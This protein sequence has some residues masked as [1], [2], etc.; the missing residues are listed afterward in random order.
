MMKF[1]FLGT[2]A[3][4][5]LA[6]AGGFSTA[7]AQ[8]SDADEIRIEDTIT[9]TA[10]KTDERLEDVPAGV[11]VL[12]EESSELLVLDGI[13]DVLRQVPNAI[14]VNAGP[15]YLSDISIRGQGGGRQGFSESSTGIYRN[16]IYIA[17][18][19]F[20]GRSFNRLDFFD[21]KTI[22]T[23][24]GPQGA[25]Y[26]RNAVG[27]AVNVINNKP[28]DAPYAQ[29]K[30]G[31]EDPERYSISGIVNTPL[32]DNVAARFGAFYIDQ[33]DGFVTDQN[34][35][36]AVDKQE[37]FG[38]R[39][40]LRAD[41]SDR[42]T[43]T[44]TIEHYD[45]TAPGFSALGQRITPNTVAL[46]PVLGGPQSGDLDPGPYEST[47]SRVGVVEIQE[48]SIFGELESD[49]DIGDFTVIVAYKQRDGDRFNEDLDSFLGFQGVDILGITTDLTV[50]QTE[51]FERLGVEM[52]LASKL[53]SSLRWL[54]GADFQTFD[55]DV[56]TINGGT[57]GLGG[58]AALATRTETFTE[59]LTSFSAFG[60][61]GFD[62]SE[63]LDLTLEARLQNDSKDFIFMREQSGATVID[64]G[65]LDDSWTRFLPAATL[66]YDVNE[67]QIIFLRAASG[68]RPGGFNTGVD[69]TSIDL[70]PYDPETAYSLE[71]GWKGRFS[72]S[73]RFGF[74]AF[75]VMTD[76]VQ[77]VSTLSTMDTTTALQN[78]GDTD[79]YGIE[80]ELSGVF[81]VGSGLVRWGGSAATTNGSFG[82]GA[83]I[84][85]SGGGNM[86]EVIDLSD[87]RVN[88]TRDYVVAANAFYFGPLSGSLDWFAGG[89]IQTEG[90]GFENASGDTSSATGR[91]LDDFF[92]ADARIGVRGDA[93][94]LSVFGKNL[95]DEVYRVQ[96]VFGNAYYNEP[97]KFGVEL[98]VEFGG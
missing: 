88:R 18:G 10:R 39:G 98:K 86:V 45:S 8:T 48:T 55:D 76:D 28:G 12:T 46:P 36:D 66:S 80:A 41:F 64:T 3:F 82:D 4:A 53:E 29:L 67:D 87:A 23:Y 70:I 77:A 26:G 93:W 79:I 92:L 27:G 47:D 24:R 97:Q 94:T 78:V 43:A 21:L 54:V 75:Y 33:N 96:T 49:W 71:A 16:G 56:A 50:R 68:Y 58:L 69:T 42:T 63:R 74:N 61:V 34:T 20:G 81:D 59:E 90:G 95:G 30:A 60:L 19:G 83:V 9:V 14:L 65:N 7:A 62:L 85:T 44:V 73:V 2:T 57:S 52:R 89:S 1:M 84:T 17:G 32:S 25:L 5:S 22:E 15:E 38:A 51:D 31:Y 40:A 11:S 72:N 6:I 35:G 13:A 37:Y 91:D